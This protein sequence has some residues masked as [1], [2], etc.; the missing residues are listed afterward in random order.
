MIPVS[1]MRKMRCK[2]AGNLPNITQLERGRA[3]I[4][5]SVFLPLIIFFMF[6]ILTLFGNMRKSMVLL[7]GTMHMSNHAEPHDVHT[8]LS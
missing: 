8:R 7:L 1:Q 6:D 3:G 5:T 4:R 2:W